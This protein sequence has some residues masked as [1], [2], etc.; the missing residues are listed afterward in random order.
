MRGRIAG[1]LVLSF[2]LL[3][4]SGAVAQTT[5]TTAVNPC[6]GQPC[7]AEPPD[8]F[9]AGTNGEVRLG[10]GSGGCW[11]SPTPSPDG[12]LEPRC[13]A[14]I[15]GAPDAL[16][17]VRAGETLTLRFSALVPTEVVL[18]RGGQSTALPAANPVR[19]RADFPIG[20]HDVEFSTR[21]L[22]GSL[23][24]DVRLDVRAPAAPRPGTGRGRISLTG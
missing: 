1:P 14:A 7:T 4:A 24:H 11:R 12:T 21:W 8:A 22:Q 3:V 16:L 20:V 17:V 15:P 23:S 6:T 13:G 18:H 10:S 2:G 5:S 19:F 9:L